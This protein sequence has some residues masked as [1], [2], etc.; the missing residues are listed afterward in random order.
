MNNK[1]S[2]HNHSYREHPETNALQSYL[3][4]TLE[5]AQRTQIQHHLDSCPVCREQL[6][7]LERLYIRLEGLP[8]LPLQR[9]FSRPVLQQIESEKQ[10]SLQLT[11]TALL[12]AVIA[13]IV[14]GLALPFLRGMSWL[15][16]LSSFQPD[17]G[18]LLSPFLS[19]L[20]ADW[21]G[22]GLDLQETGRDFLVSLTADPPAGLTADQLWPWMLLVVLVAIAANSL[23]L[24]D[25]SGIQINQQK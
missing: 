1:N 11:W 15:S 21:L 10:V 25:R 22:W 17:M 16:Q 4:R 13:G 5:P 3:D 7:R 18:S 6:M 23:L 9:D 8:E 24:S 19:G 20:A 2:P 12:Q 14:L